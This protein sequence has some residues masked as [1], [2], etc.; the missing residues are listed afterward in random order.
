MNTS[1]QQH[2]KPATQGPDAQKI[3]MKFEV[4]AIPATALRRDRRY[5]V[6]RIPGGGAG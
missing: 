6:R 2:A 4:V 1:T 5:A 3:A